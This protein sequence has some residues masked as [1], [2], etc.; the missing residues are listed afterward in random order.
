MSRKRKPKCERLPPNLDKPKD[1][2]V[3]PPE[4]EPCP[5][6]KGSGR[7]VDPYGWTYKERFTTCPLCAGGK[8]VMDPGD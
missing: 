3:K 5:K 7:V 2:R 8:Y 4:L 6:C 1:G